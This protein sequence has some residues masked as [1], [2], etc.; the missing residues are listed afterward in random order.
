LNKILIPIFLAIFLSLL[1]TPSL[2]NAEIKLTPP[3][4]TWQPSP[5]NNSTAMV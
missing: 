5:N 4:H 2:T 3:P 1:W